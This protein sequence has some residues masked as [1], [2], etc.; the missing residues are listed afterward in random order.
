VADRRDAADGL[1]RPLT[2]RT[3]VG[4]CHL[5]SADQVR[6]LSRVHAVGAAGH[7]Q[8]RRPV[9]AEHEAVR[10]RPELT[11]ELRGC[12]GGRRRAFR[13]FPYLARDAQVA[14]HSCESREVDWHGCRLAG[15]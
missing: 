12:G 13:Q 1:T 11:A 3:R 7:D 6:Y 8:E 14:E 2:D 15:A 4:S 5:G 10:D 9:R